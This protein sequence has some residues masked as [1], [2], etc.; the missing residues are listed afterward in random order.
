MKKT[1]QLARRRLGLMHM[2][3]LLTLTTVLYSAGR[4]GLLP[5]QQAVNAAR[6]AREQAEELRSEIYGHHPHDFVA[7]PR[8]TYRYVTGWAG[9][10][11][12]WGDGLLF[13]RLAYRSVRNDGETAE[14]VVTVRAPAGATDKEII[15]A[16]RSYFTTGCRCEHDCCAHWQS[17]AGI[18]R[19]VKRRQWVMPINYFRNV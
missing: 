4:A 8:L 18:P 3:G 9:E 6:N 16:L 15:T 10:C 1:E 5:E 19:R 7:R 13:R 14:S 11:D 2:R 12:E 17:Y